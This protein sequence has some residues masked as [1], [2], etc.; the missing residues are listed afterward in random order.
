MLRMPSSRLARRAAKQYLIRR[1]FRVPSGPVMRCRPLKHRGRCVA[2][3]LAY[4]DGVP[5]TAVPCGR[6]AAREMA[7]SHPAKVRATTRANQPC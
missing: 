7:S 1:R 3:R 4:A 2:R 5:A 6:Q